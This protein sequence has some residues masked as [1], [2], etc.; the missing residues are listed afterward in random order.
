M[1]VPT[2]SPVFVGTAGWSMPAG[3]G[4]AGTHLER[5]ARVFR[6]VEITSSFYR[7]HSVATY[8]RWAGATPAGLDARYTA[9]ELSL[10]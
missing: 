10:R 6:C 7:S 2:R 1:P 9:R 5:Y 4:G 8:V 3:T